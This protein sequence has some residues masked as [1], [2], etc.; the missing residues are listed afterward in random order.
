MLLKCP[1]T[2]IIEQARKRILYALISIYKVSLTSSRRPAFKSLV[3]NGGF[4]DL[5]TERE[6]NSLASSS[7][8]SDLGRSRE[9]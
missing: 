4:V 1:H 3:A 2:N 7:I 9:K 6:F 5:L 8:T